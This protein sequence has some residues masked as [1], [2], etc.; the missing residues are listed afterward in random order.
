MGERPL[1]EEL[2]QLRI[3]KGLTRKDVAELSGLNARSIER[4]ENGNYDSDM[5]RW[6]TICKVLTGLGVKFHAVYE[7]PR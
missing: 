6:A 4:I 5:I 1:G 3:N 7:Q 2:M